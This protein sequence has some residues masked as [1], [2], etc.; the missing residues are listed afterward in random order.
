MGIA[1]KPIPV[2]MFVGMLA[3]RPEDLLASE[4][5]LLRAFGPIDLRGDIVPWEHTAY[6]AHEM[7]HNLKRQFIF[8]ETLMDPGALPCAKQVTNQ[9]EAADSG[10][11]CDGRKRRV[12]NLDPGYVT[13]AKVVLATTK[14][15]SHR[16]YI[17][18]YIYAEVTLK[19]DKSL[20]EF[21][22]LD[23]TYPDF[24]AEHTRRLFQHARDLLRSALQR[25]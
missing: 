24:R 15:F 17:G 7:G 6:Y 10:F 19:Y 5:Q 12:I 9:I 23:H 11:M 14:D 13:E 16:V 25:K 18:E 21:L 1:R 8:F 20:S 22:P 3:S 4:E 2:K